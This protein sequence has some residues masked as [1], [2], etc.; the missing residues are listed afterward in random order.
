MRIGSD[1]QERDILTQ[2]REAAAKRSL[3]L[4]H[5][6]NQMNSPD[7]M[8]STEEIRAVVFN[9]VLVEDYPEDMRG[10]SCLMLGWGTGDRPLHVVCAPKVGYLAI[11]TTY[12]PRST[13]WE[14]DWQTRRKG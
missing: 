14:P 11:I 13:Q 3:F 10:H 12:L 9:V 5:A 2:V 8:I 6:I 4:P 7:R 1:I